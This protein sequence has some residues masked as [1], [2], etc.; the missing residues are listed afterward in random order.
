MTMQTPIKSTNN[1]ASPSNKV[2]PGTLTSK[3]RENGKTFLPPTVQT[4]AAFSPDFPAIGK[5]DTRPTFLGGQY[6]SKIKVKS[7][8]GQ[9]INKKDSRNPQEIRGLESEDEAK[10]TQTYDVAS[11]YKQKLRMRNS[12]ERAFANQVQ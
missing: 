4:T 2:I 12:I 7:E 5:R 9:Y 11:Y 10:L 3:I 8:V 1:R 6:S